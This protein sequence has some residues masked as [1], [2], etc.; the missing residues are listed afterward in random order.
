MRSFNFFLKN[1]LQSQNSSLKGTSFTLFGKKW[2]KF[3]VPI[4]SWFLYSNLRICRISQ[5]RDKNS[6]C[7]NLNCLV[8]TCFSSFSPEVFGAKFGNS[9]NDSLA[10]RLFFRY[11]LDKKWLAWK[12]EI[13]YSKSFIFIQ[14]F[15]CQ[16]KII[17]SLSMMINDE[18][19]LRVRSNFWDEILGRTCS[20]SKEIESSSWSGC[21]SFDF[22][23]EGYFEVLIVVFTSL[24]LRRLD[25]NFENF[26]LKTP[27]TP[28]S[29]S[30]N[31][32]QGISNFHP[33]SSSIMMYSNFSL[34]PKK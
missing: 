29:D 20:N 28:D 13:W 30:W 21:T 12:L 22:N 17:H 7:A 25:F 34:E 33:F 31:L 24:F 15:I 26:Q 11:Y 4:C 6:R 18:I 2:C 32:S 23:F 1:D 19:E 14:I 9:K 10:S 8:F 16:L 3:E 27:C 5:L